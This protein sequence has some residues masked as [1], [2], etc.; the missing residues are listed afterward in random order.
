MVGKNI[1]K[2]GKTT[3]EKK[4]IVPLDYWS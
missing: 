2:K 1:A 4:V 3:K